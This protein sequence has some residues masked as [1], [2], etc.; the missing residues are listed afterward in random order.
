VRLVLAEL[1]AA[2]GDHPAAARHLDVAHAE[3][4]AVGAPV[5]ASRAAAGSRRHDVGAPNS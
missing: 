1:A 4:T 2:R 3:F 5:W